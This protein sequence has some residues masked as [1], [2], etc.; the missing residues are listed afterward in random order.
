MLLL[1]VLT[2]NGEL[3]VG[4]NG[5][6]YSLCDAEKNILKLSN[7]T[8]TDFAVVYD[9][10]S[11]NARYYVNKAPAYILVG[12]DAQAAADVAVYDTTFKSVNGVSEINCDLFAKL[13]SNSLD[14][15]SNFSNHKINDNDTAE[16]IGFQENSIV[17]GIRIVAG[18]D[19]L[20]YDNVGF[21]IEIYENG[22]LKKSEDVFENIVFSKIV[23]EDKDITSEKYGY[24]YFTTV[25]VVDLP[26]SIP[27][28]SYILAR[29]YATVADVKHYDTQVKI[30]VTADGY[31]IENDS[32]EDENT[33]DTEHFDG[34]QIVLLLGQSN[35]SGRGLIPYVEPIS[36]DRITAFY[37]DLGWVKMTEPIHKD[38]S[39]AGIGLS[40]S[41]A[42][43]FVETFDCELGLVPLAVG[44]SSLSDWSEGG[45]LYENAVTVAKEAMKSGE[46]CAILWHQG[47]SDRTST[48]YAEKFKTAMDS[49]I[50]ELE[51][52][53]D[54]IAIITG[55]LCDRGNY[56]SYPIENINT[57]LNSDV[58]KNYFPNYAV[59]SAEG[60]TNDELEDSHFDAPSLRV[61]GYR[62]FEGFY[63]ALMDKECTYE[64]SQNP[65]DYRIEPQVVEKENNSYYLADVDF[66]CYTDGA[67]ITG[68]S[69]T[70]DISVSS[71]VDKYASVNR[72]T[73]TDPYISVAAAPTV[74]NDIVVEMDFRL[75]EDYNFTTTGSSG[76]LIKITPGS[77]SIVTV[78][79][80]SEGYILDNNTKER[81][82]NPLS[83]DE[84][85]HVKVVCHMDSNTKDIYV[86]GTGYSA[87]LLGVK[88]HDTYDTKTYTVTKIVI[89]QC[90][91]IMRGTLDVDNIK[92]YE[93]PRTIS[94]MSDNV[95][96]LGR[97][98]EL[99]T[100]LALDH[101]ASGFA[102]NFNGS[103]NVVLNVTS[104]DVAYGDD[105]KLCVTVDGETAKNI[106][107]PKGTSDVLIAKELIAGD[108]TIEVVKESDVK[109]TVTVNTVAFTGT[110]LE[111]PADA[112]TC[113]EFI[114]DSITAGYGLSESEEGDHH[115]ATLSYA[116]RTAKALGA[117]YAIFARSGMGIAY[118]SGDVNIFENRYKYLSFNRNTTDI[119]APERTPD[120]V[121]I[122]L[123]QND[124]SQW[125]N[126]GGNVQGDKYND[127]TF[128]AKFANM[129]NT[130][131]GLYGKDVPILFVYGCMESP[132]YAPLA[133]ERSKYLIEN[134]Y[135]EAEGYN[136]TYTTL[137]TNREG[138]S[139]HPTADGA[140]VQADE[141]ANYIFN[142]YSAFN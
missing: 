118:A 53:K 134:V 56:E 95:K 7:S 94:E 92:V 119:Y 64:Y 67:V 42:K 59:A 137:S 79:L 109:T 18:V 48:T 108:H 122:N 104:G 101:S 131:T 105:T 112:D 72:T 80:D 55:E 24:A 29:S 15:V 62:Y 41:F 113:I 125:Y 50:G 12:D 106:L 88:L 102:F 128:D 35:M 76:A 38:S 83:P 110:L 78:R 142:N 120:L 96:L 98:F 17:N 45:E 70:G 127:A 87:E 135:T 85:T 111:K 99:D 11:G 49:L 16:I 9:D 10:I 123:A 19:S 130:V 28:N 20:Y 100:G 3:V 39:N 129:I 2:S 5:K 63:E 139:N 97:A 8:A 68:V 103:G 40:A 132:S 73:T 69:F 124:N 51:L 74:G 22:T 82:G 37:S 138:L 84:W 4:S 61:L 1:R 23:G 54:N 90:G 21:E 93:R 89:A 34:K 140:A 117:D 75:S 47:E 77:N 26:T 136:I 25:N 133:T 14:A 65:L 6:Y 121:V 44:G 30:K 86:S 71:G 27:A 116:Y 36:D 114:G 107:V 60:L 126:N 13:P 141:L 31:F 115:D 32:S 58:L 57:T 46:I 43:A 66:N 91:K 33:D 81:V 52:D